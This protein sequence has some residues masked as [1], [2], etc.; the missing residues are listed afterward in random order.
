MNVFNYNFFLLQKVAIFKNPLHFFP[1]KCFNSLIPR[2]YFSTNGI[3][4]RFYLSGKF[5]NFKPHKIL[6]LT[7]IKGDTV[8]NFVYLIKRYV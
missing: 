2:S 7:K 3:I 1:L 5:C 8:F 6:T 4:M